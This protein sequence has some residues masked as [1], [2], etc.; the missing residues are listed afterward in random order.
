MKNEFL[1]FRGGKYLVQEGEES[2]WLFYRYFLFRVRFPA[3]VYSL[4]DQIIKRLLPSL[5]RLH[6]NRLWFRRKAILDSDSLIIRRGTSIEPSQVSLKKSGTKYWVEKKATEC[7]LSREEQFYAKYK[8]NRSCIRLPQMQRNDNVMRSEFIMS[9]NMTSMIRERRLSP[10]H[11]IF[12]LQR[13]MNEID[14]FYDFQNRCL[15]HG[16]LTPD[17]LY[18]FGDGFVLIDFADSEIYTPRFDKYVLMKRI[19]VE[20]RLNFDYLPA[21][22]TDHELLQFEAHLRKKK[23]EK[24]S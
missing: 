12:L 1:L 20:G 9:Q 23:N 11:I 4:L 3:K 22:F 6:L 18:I 19:A 16:D 7:Q 13:L 10:R 15:I 5:F 14:I 2:L 8:L 21:N 17:N 24:H